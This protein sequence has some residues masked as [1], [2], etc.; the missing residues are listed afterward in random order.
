[1][2]SRKVIVLNDEGMHMRPAGM[3]VAAVNKYPDTDVTLKVDGKEINAKSVMQIMAAGLKKDSEIEIIAGGADE[4][5][6]LDEL[7][8]MF[9]NEFKE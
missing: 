9:K 3:I 1:M 6:I 4:E 5:K 2:M 7:E 8:E